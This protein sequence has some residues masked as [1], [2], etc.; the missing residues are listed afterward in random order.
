MSR[1]IWPL[2][3]WAKRYDRVGDNGLSF[4]AGRAA[5]EP[6]R[7]GLLARVRR[8]GAEG[9]PGRPGA[10]LEA[11]QARAW[12]FDPGPPNRRN[13]QRP[14]AELRPGR[15]SAARRAGAA[16][17]PSSARGRRTGAAISATLTAG[18]PASSGTAATATPGLRHGGMP[19]QD[20][21]AR[22]RL[23]P[24][25]ARRRSST[26][27][28]RRNRSGTT[29]KKKKNP[30]LPAGA[31]PAGCVADCRSRAHRLLRTMGRHL[32][33]PAQVKSRRSRRSNTPG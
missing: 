15:R 32:R 9:P 6:C 33:V 20:R 21:P 25:R 5:A 14:G 18:S 23:Q 22:H 10:A 3:A 24:E 19:E 8:A 30:F 4:P 31:A 16:G 17:D 28:A 2:A 1:A 29:K 27:G 26:A 11:M 12:T 7:H 13:R